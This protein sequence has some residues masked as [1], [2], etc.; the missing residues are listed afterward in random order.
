MVIK[1]IRPLYSIPKSGFHWY[2]TY[3]Y[4]HI[5]R[6]EMRRTTL[7]PGVL[8]RVID[9]NLYGLITLQVEDSLGRGTQTF[10]KEEDEVA[11]Q[12]RAKHRKTKQSNTIILNG[13]D[14]THNKETTIKMSK[15]DKIEKITTAENLK[16]I[17]SQRAMM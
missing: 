9:G 1:V 15:N 14:V 3:F 10:F 13:S 12:L 8:I 5:E 6:L 2:L 11:K 17:I 7:Y 16:S 4:H